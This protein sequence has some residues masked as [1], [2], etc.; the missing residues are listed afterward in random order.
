VGWVHGRDDA[1]SVGVGGY[2]S[3]QNWGAGRDINGWAGTLD[4]EIPLASRLSL[5]GEF[6]GGS[7]IGGLGAAGGHSILASDALSNPNTRVRGLDTLGGWSQVRFRATT[8]L[9]FNGGYGQ[10]NPFSRE[11]RQFSA[12]QTQL[13]PELGINRDI[14]L[15]S[16]YHPRSNLLLSLEYRHFYSARLLSERQ[17]AEH[18]NAAIGV[19]F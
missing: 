14:M 11:L 5:R 12:V 15:N 13:D 7:A 2:F 19:L 10:D 18:V 6:Y 16:I 4:W 17:T 1:F 9:E 8:K 3:P